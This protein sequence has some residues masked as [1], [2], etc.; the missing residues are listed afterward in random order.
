MWNYKT[1]TSPLGR[2]PDLHEWYTISSNWNVFEPGAA[3]TEENKPSER[4]FIFF[5]TNSPSKYYF[6][7]C[8]PN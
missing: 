6:M 7:H 5:L 8:G 3:H 1:L 2:D 4:I